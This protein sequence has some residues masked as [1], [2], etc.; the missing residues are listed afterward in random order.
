MTAI[1]S[2][3]TGVWSNTATWTGGVVP[4]EGDTVT[5][6][7]THT[8]TIDQDITV[9]ADTSTAAIAI[10]SGGKLEYL[11][12]AVADYTLTCKGDLTVS[13]TLEIGTVANPIPSTRI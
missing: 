8:V 10:A 4:V 13:G 9:G 5:I 6:Q 11:S 7:N 3:A 12:T 1:T 2:A